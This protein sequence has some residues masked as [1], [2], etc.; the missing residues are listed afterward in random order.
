[1]ESNGK[2]DKP[3]LWRD[4]VALSTFVNQ[5]LDQHISFA[6]ASYKGLKQNG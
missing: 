4:D 6:K 1:M 3:P 2:R 5:A